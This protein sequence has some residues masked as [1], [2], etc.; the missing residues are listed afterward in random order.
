MDPGIRQV[1]SKALIG[2]FLRNLRRAIV[3]SD[4]SWLGGFRKLIGP[5][6][7]A[8]FFARVLVCGGV[9]VRSVASHH[10]RGERQ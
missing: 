2:D 10:G 5:E 9:I 4:T 3:F 1:T 7:H 6:S 8:C